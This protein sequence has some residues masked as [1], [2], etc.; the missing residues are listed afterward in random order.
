MSTSCNC[1]CLCMSI[2]SAV[3]TLG[4]LQ[5]N[6]ALFFWARFS[7]FV[8]Y[9]WYFDIILG[10]IYTTRFVYFLEMYL[11]DSKASRQAYYLSHFYSNFVI[12]VVVLAILTMKTLQWGH[13][14]W[15]EFGC[16]FMWS[17]IA[18]YS[19]VML[20]QYVALSNR[21]LRTSKK[22]DLPGSFNTTELE[23]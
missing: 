20:Q 2:D 10:I 6:A 19:T 21:R 16:W 4:M 9:Y 12:V 22:D 3:I 7:V 14:P 11:G 18:S 1:Y 17:G 13:W 5:L 15:L 8:P 23:V